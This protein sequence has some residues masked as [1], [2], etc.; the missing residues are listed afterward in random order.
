MVIVDTNAL[1]YV[2]NSKDIRHSDFAPL[3][4]FIKSRKNILAWG[5][6]TYIEELKRCP[7]YLDLFIEFDKQGISR[8]FPNKPIDTYEGYIYSLINNVAF[9]D[10]HIIALQVSSKA[11]IVCSVDERSYPYL[12]DQIP[13]VKLYPKRHR[14]PKIYSKKVNQDLLKK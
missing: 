7:T 4:N 3:F 1:S 13:K 14:R 10:A 2:F 6:T 8:K 11:K 12:K 5:G 9:D